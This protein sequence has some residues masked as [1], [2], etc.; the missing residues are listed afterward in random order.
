[1]TYQKHFPASLHG[2]EPDRLEQLSRELV[3]SFRAVLKQQQIAGDHD[4][5]FERFYLPL[6]AT[7]AK[8]AADRS[9]PLVVGINGAQGSGKTTLCHV[10]QRLLE[11]GFGLRIAGFSIDDLYLTRAERLDLGRTVHPLLTTRGVPGTHDVALGQQL[12]DEL[13]SNHADRTVAI[14][15]FDKAR[16]DRTPRSAWRSVQTPIDLVLFEGWCVGAVPQAEVALA[17]PVNVLERVEDPQ[18]IW[19]RYVNHR[20]QD[21]YARLFARIDRLIML[22]I[23][24]MACVHSWRGLQ[25]RKLVA[26]STKE[27]QSGIMDEAALKR[28]IMHYERLTRSM[29]AEMPLRADL[30]LLLDNEHRLAGVR[31]NFSTVTKINNGA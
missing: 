30:A 18:G 6:A 11:D 27:D 12:L 14:P 8:A 24:D 4:T 7:L 3:A 2:L 20:L 10:L 16:D 22:E 29:L 31:S 21:D 19:R 9:S 1:M 26:Q 28:F 25:E 17:Q 23:P 5:L 13:T 15:V